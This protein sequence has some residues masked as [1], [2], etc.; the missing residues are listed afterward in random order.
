MAPVPVPLLLEEQELLEVQLAQPIHGWPVQL[1]PE[2][3]LYELDD[4]TLGGS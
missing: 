1:A 3:P 4:H 2:L